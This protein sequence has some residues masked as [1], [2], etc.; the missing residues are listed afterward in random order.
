MYLFDFPQ[1][2]GSKANKKKKKKNE[3]NK[4]KQ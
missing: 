2:Y 3:K 1:D 4:N